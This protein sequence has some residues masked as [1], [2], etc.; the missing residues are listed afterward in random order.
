MVAPTYLVG[1][2]INLAIAKKN[3]GKK[4]VLHGAWTCSFKQNLR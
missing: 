3:E 4:K 2:Q 1:I